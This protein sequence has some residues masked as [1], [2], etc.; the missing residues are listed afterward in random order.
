MCDLI[1]DVGGTNMRLARIL[2]SGQMADQRVFPSKGT[3]TLEQA[4]MQFSNDL[5]LTPERAVVAAAGVVRNGAVRLTNADQSFSEQSLQQAL[6]LRSAKVLN[7]FEAAAWSLANVSPND[8]TMLQ[9]TGDFTQESCLILGPGTGLGVGGLVWSDG[10]PCAVPGEGGHV[11][12]S[13]RDREDVDVFEALRDEWPEVSVGS[14]LGV[15]AEAILSGTGLPY[16]YRSIAKTMDMPSVC[17]TAADIFAAAKSKTDMAAMRSIT[18]FAKYLGGV[19]GDLGLVFAA[20]GGVFISG[21]VANANAWMFDET[22]MDAFNAGGR[23]TQWRESLPVYLYHQ[24][25]FG[26]FG[27]RN[28]LKYSEE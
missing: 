14:G 20:K 3:L 11:T 26:L 2:A 21:G 13:P 24:P 7:D 17:K 23:H 9:G 19:A 10:V 25:D 4:F 27:A 5:D 18:L 8:V 15:E 12:V 16:F 28:F 6:G 22:F 1:A